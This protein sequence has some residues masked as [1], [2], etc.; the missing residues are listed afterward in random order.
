MPPEPS[1]IDA[2]PTRLAQIILNLLNNAAKFTPPGGRIWLTVSREPGRKGGPGSVV[3]SV[4]D[5]GI[6]I[7]DEMKE[8]I[9]GLFMQGDRSLERTHSGLGVGLTLVRSLLQLHDGSIDVR[10]AG[11]GRGSEFV[12]RLP[13]T[14]QRDAGLDGARERAPGTERRQ[15]AG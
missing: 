4:R 13:D 10:S 2:D 14:G 11:P 8:R 12:V 7:A 1:W 5:S 3:I 15:P 6:G 9:F